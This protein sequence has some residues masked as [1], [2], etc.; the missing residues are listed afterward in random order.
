MIESNMYCIN[1][2]V[3]G[4]GNKYEIYMYVGY[5]TFLFCTF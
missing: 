5:E 3:P 1:V 2:P 4:T